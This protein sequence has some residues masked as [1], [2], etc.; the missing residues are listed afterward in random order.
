MWIQFAPP[1]VRW[2]MYAL[3]IVCVI[4]FLL[5][6]KD[7]RRRM[8]AGARRRRTRRPSS[9][10]LDAPM[11]AP[12]QWTPTVSAQW[13]DPPRPHSRSLDRLGTVA[14]AARILLAVS[15]LA[16]VVLLFW[17]AIAFVLNVPGWR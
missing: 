4:A 17:M 14:A 7:E 9:S 15:A 3:F 13:S 6:P 11:D 12:T 10:T 8:L 2:L 1:A 16:F 5:M